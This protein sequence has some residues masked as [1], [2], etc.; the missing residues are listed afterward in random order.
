MTEISVQYR[1]SRKD[2]EKLIVLSWLT[3]Q[4]R[5]KIYHDVMSAAVAS[6]AIMLEVGLKYSVP[7]DQ[8]FLL[9]HDTDFL[10]RTQLGIKLH[11]D[12]KK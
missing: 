6:N 12:D 1:L 11:A 9:I 3:S 10:I 5:R 2:H 4:T 7:R 8:L